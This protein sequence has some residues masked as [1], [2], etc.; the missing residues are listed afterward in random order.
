[1]PTQ[2]IFVG[3]S[4]DS[5]VIDTLS[6][7]LNIRIFVDSDEGDVITIGDCDDCPDHECPDCDGSSSAS[8]SGSGDGG[9]PEC[10]ECLIVVKNYRRANVSGSVTVD[11]SQYARKFEIDKIIFTKMAG[12]PTTV[13]AGWAAGTEDIMFLTDLGSLETGIPVSVSIE[14]V[15]PPTGNI[16]Y[17]TIPGATYIIDMILIRYK[18]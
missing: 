8:G 6:E 15:P 4:S 11:V 5:I 17:F 1:M 14:Q 9:C 16:V 13:K 12:S 7:E 3:D 2:R 10:P 18:L